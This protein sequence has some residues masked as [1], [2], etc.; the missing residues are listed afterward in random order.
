MKITKIQ[1]VKY[2]RN[3]LPATLRHQQ[4]IG[5]ILIGLRRSCR[6]AKDLLTCRA[7]PSSLKE[8]GPGVHIR[9]SSNVLTSPPNSPNYSSL[10]PL[11]P[12]CYRMITL[13]EEAEIMN[14][15]AST[16]R[17]FLLAT[18]NTTRLWPAGAHRKLIEKVTGGRAPIKIKI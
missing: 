6:V 8:R 7:V 18:R 4:S 3:P 17:A 12:N 5:G 2:S 1:A 10:Q 13:E 9:P 15:V 11:S 16:M 14:W